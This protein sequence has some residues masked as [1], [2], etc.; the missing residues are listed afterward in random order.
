MQTPP[1]PPKP[2]AEIGKPELTRLPRLYFA[3]RFYRAFV[4]GVCRTVISVCTRVEVEGLENFPRTGP[5]LVVINHLG[6][7][8]TP[9]LVGFVPAVLDTLGKIELYDFPLLGKLMEWYGIIWL[10]RGLPD[11]RAIRAALDGL[12]EGRIIVIAPEGR[13]SLTGELEEATYGA[14]FL[15]LKAHVPVVPVA[16]IG[17]ENM[18]VY[19]HL[20]RLRRPLVKL[21]VGQ[22]FVLAEQAGCQDAKREGTRQIMFVLASLLPV[23]YRGIYQ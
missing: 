13:Y 11:R 6:D 17:T 14:A 1:S 16:L 9:L 5:A 4:R 20:R 18:N 19:G 10:H 15:A 22:P 2:V 12:A 23:E 21:K 3:R 8:D 7:A